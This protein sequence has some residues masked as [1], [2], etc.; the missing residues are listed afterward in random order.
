MSDTTHTGLVRRHLAVAAAVGSSDV[1][2][3]H[4]GKL[5]AI[6]LWRE[7]PTKAPQATECFPPPQYPHCARDHQQAAMGSE[8]KLCY[9]AGLVGRQRDHRSEGH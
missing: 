4:H 2:S 7:L 8:N 3:A 9:D 5:H 1:P 6:L